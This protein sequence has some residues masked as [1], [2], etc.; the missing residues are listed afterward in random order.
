MTFRTRIAMSFTEPTSNDA[1]Q[2]TAQ[3]NED[4]R[5]QQQGSARHEGDYAPGRRMDN[6]LEIDQ[7]LITPDEVTEGIYGQ[8]K[9]QRLRH[10]VRNVHY[11][12]QKDVDH[13]KD[14]HELR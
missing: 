4:I 3:A 1:R 5:P 12:D 2:M 13:E 8:Y 14:A 9:P 6:R 11:R 10:H 7:V